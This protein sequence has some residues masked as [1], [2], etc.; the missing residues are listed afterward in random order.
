MDLTHN[1]N[2]QQLY[3]GNSGLSFV[4]ITDEV[5]GTL[6]V[7]FCDSSY[8][9]T[10]SQGTEMIAQSTSFKPTELPFT[11]VNTTTGNTILFDSHF[12]LDGLTLSTDTPEVGTVITA[13]LTQTNATA[14]FVWFS[15]STPIKNATNSSFTVT[16]AQIGQ[17]ITCVAIGTGDYTGT[18]FATTLAVPGFDLDVPAGLTL[19]AEETTVTAAWSAVKNAS[20][21]TLECVIDGESSKILLTDI[22]GTS[23]SLIGAYGKSY[24]IRIKA[25]GTD[26]YSDSDYSEVASIT[27]RT[28]LTSLA[29]SSIAPEVGTEIIASLIPTDATADYQ[30]FFGETLIEGATG[31]TFIVTED[32]IGQTITCVAT[33]TGDYSGTVSMTTAVVPVPVTA[34]DAPADVALSVYNATVTA[35]WSAVENASSY[36][37]E[38]KPVGTENWTALPGLEDTTASFVGVSGTM[39][40]VRVKAVGTGDYSDST[41]AEINTDKPTGPVVA[42][43]AN[44]VTVSWVDDSPAADSVRY[45]VAGTTRWT[46]KKLNAGITEM[47]F[48]ATI[49]ANYDIEV[50]L[51][52]QE[53]NV[54]Q[55]S[56]IVLDQPRLTSIR[57]ELKDDT[58]QVNVTNYAAKNLAANVKQ[59][60]VSV[61]GVMTT[62]KI[63][64]QQGETALANGGKVA[65]SNGLF[66]FSE[67]NSNTSYKVTIS[68][69]DG[70]SVSKTSSALTVK[71]LKAPYLPPVIVSA[72][73][74]SDTAVTVTW[75]TAYGK[76]STTPAQKYT[77][78]YSTDGNKWTNATTGATGN[79][80]TIQRLKGG[81][82]YQVRV[83]ATKDAAFEASAPSGVL[84]A[85]TLTLPKTVLDKASVKDDT[86]KLNVTNYATSNLVNAPTLNVKSDKFGEAAIAIQNGSG[87]A[88]FENGMVAAFENGAL[89]FT[90]VPSNTQQK[91]QVN[92]SD[93]VCTTAWTA[94]LT[95]KTTIAPYNKPVLTNAT[96]TSSTTVLVEWDAVTGKN[97]TVLAPSYTVQYTT[98][99]TRWINANTRVVGTSFTIPNLKPNTPYR[100]AVI[101]NKDARFNASQPSES[102]EV[103][104][105]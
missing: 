90:N 79:S 50:L 47:S 23:A 36:T 9:V 56:A 49:G 98:D 65:F 21:Y 84:S 91:I 70:H 6:S 42:I 87:S 66:T 54:L 34:L 33:G 28:P 40:N 99:G 93:G 46:V 51:D 7:Y 72:N 81:V 15:G 58:F 1:A 14:A 2:L 48:N 37:L 26:N 96:A 80:Y 17:S 38:Y 97:S 102:W 57:N 68:F 88:T 52:Q 83:L 75:E 95:V 10:N 18:I 77:V 35:S 8:D 105:L 64:D 62:L 74:V 32:Q 67:M 100:V 11:A 30:W 41:Y 61:N 4:R 27:L 19:S 24:T 16:E 25:V 85:Q 60:I 3:V 45:R 55:G 89:T 101:A 13:E 29:L 71:T 53:N 73:A 86:F 82:E 103:R 59:A 5:I 20:G 12:H 69:S 94:A 31:S 104:T 44:K 22:Q 39:Y 92:F 78:Q 76:K 43:N 63:A